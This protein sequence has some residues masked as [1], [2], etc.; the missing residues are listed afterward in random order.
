M[1]VDHLRIVNG[2]VV[3]A[4][5][6]LLAGRVPSRTASTANV[7]PSAG[8]GEE[9]IAEFRASCD[10]LLAV[11]NAAPTLRTAVRY[12]HPWFGRLDAFGWKFLGAY[13]LG[14]HRRQIETIMAH[15]K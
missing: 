8:V 12:A 4:V 14:L 3:K 13:H 10:Q 2:T 15:L 9:A 1:T 7:K 6:E 11:G 5:A